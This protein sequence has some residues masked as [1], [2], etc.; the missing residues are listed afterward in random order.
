MAVGPRG[1]R[2][3]PSRGWPLEGRGHSHAPMVRAVM[4][5]AVGF[6]AGLFGHPSYRRGCRGREFLG[7]G[8]GTAVNC[9]EIRGKS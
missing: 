7:G 3:E 4:S 2:A 8:P 6:T 1:K 9:K 5:M